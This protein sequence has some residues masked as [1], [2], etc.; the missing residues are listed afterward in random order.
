MNPLHASQI[1]AAVDQDKAQREQFQTALD[2]VAICDL[3]KR[4]LTIDAA[5]VKAGVPL[6]TFEDWFAAD[7]GFR[8][9]CYASKAASHK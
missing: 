7:E 5:C 6:A 2:Q 3:L 1:K 4:G 9:A 8:I